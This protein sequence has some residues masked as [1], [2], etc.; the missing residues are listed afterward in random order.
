LRIAAVI[1]SD[2]CLQFHPCVW[3]FLLTCD[4]SIT[5]T[6]TSEALNHPRTAVHRN[7]AI[8]ELIRAF[9]HIL[10]PQKFHDDKQFNRVDN[11]SQIPDTIENNTTSLCYRCTYVNG[12]SYCCNFILLTSSLQYFTLLLATRIDSSFLDNTISYF[13]SNWLIS[14]TNERKKEAVFS[15]HSVNLAVFIPP[16]GLWGYLSKVI[17][18]CESK[19][20]DPFSFEHNFRKYCPIL[21]IASLL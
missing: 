9:D 17:L 15:K 2:K 18:R 16:V 11:H 20:L 19:K 10:L 21:I 12:K 4:I 13:H 1:F 3:Y 14:K 6:R 5:V 7:A 8:F